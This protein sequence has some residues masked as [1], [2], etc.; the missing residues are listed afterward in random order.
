MA[1][2]LPYYLS[3]IKRL[4]REVENEHR[5]IL[6]ERQK[7]EEKDISSNPFATNIAASGMKFVTGLAGKSQVCY[8]SG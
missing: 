2:A 4:N 6:E 1:K 8:R 7:V 3:E 5:R